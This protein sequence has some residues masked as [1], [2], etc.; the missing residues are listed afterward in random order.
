M[1]IRERPRCG[2]FSASSFDP[3]TTG[4]ESPNRDTSVLV[5]A[6]VV[7]CLGQLIGG[8]REIRFADC[9]AEGVR[10]TRGSDQGELHPQEKGV[11][12]ACR[13]APDQFVRSDSTDQRTFE[14]DIIKFIAEVS[15]SSAS[16]T[17][18]YWR[19]PLRRSLETNRLKGVDWDQVNPF[20]V[21]SNE[22]FAE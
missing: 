9:N 2:S 17:T 6:L 16:S 14:E 15:K 8:E 21:R 11:S 12:Q 10:G 22:I 13:H 1:V 3:S 4:E 18:A 7:V 5:Q 19:N 20:A